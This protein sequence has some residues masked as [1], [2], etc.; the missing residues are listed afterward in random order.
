MPLKLNRELFITMFSYLCHVAPSAEETQTAGLKDYMSI[1]A[2]SADELGKR[3][4]EQGR[5]DEAKNI[6]H[7]VADYF[8]SVEAEISRRPYEPNNYE[9]SRMIE[10]DWENSKEEYLRDHNPSSKDLSEHLIHFSSLDQEAADQVTKEF[11]FLL[12]RW[13]ILGAKDGDNFFNLVMAKIFGSEI[14]PHTKFLS[15]RGSER[16]GTDWIS[17]RTIG[18]FSQALKELIENVTYEAN[19]DGRIEGA[20]P[21]ARA[22]WARQYMDM[23][24][25]RTPRSRASQN[26]PDLLR[27]SAKVALYASPGRTAGEW[28]E[29]FREAYVE[30]EMNAHAERLKEDISNNSYGE[31]HSRI[32]EELESRDAEAG[33]TLGLANPLLPMWESGSFATVVDEGMLQFI[34]PD[35]PA[36]SLDIDLINRLL[37]HVY[38]EF[39]DIEPFRDVLDAAQKGERAILQLVQE[40]G[41]GANG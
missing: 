11:T 7:A 6:R 12:Q 35:C 13:I 25:G 4:A 21:R 5:E 16:Y 39:A 18:D 20:D 31:I 28:I 26:F 10:E 32:R 1:S 23:V 34:S 27:R 8:L 36:Y 17:A 37:S 9:V 24:T 38:G 22:M 14:E 40:A 15:A 33:E 41:I 3:L 29:P 30:E 19:Q 2:Q